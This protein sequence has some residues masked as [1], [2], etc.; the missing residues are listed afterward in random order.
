MVAQRV[1]GV[2]LLEADD[3]DDLARARHFQAVAAIAHHA[4]DAGD[5][6]AA[7]DG[8]VQHVVLGVQLA[9]VD[10]HEHQVAGRLA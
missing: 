3:G 9:R 1:A 5:A 7:S 4:E 10:A 2:R 6:L 8:R